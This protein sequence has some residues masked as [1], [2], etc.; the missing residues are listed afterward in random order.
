MQ[1]VSRIALGAALALG[2]AIGAASAQ[3]P[4]PAQA[5]PFAYS[6]EERAALAPVQAAVAAKDYV[7]A[8][9]V[10]AAARTA[11]KSADAQYTFARYQLDIGVATQNNQLQAAGID[12]MI[13]SGRPAAT[14][15]PALYHSQGALAASLGDYKKAETAFARLVEAAPNDAEALV[16]LAEIRNDLGKQAEAVALIDRA[17][18]VRTAA[19]QPVPQN[20]YKRGLNIASASR[21]PAESIKFGRGLAQAYPGPVNWRDA[22]LTYRDF[23]APDPESTLDLLRLM[24]ATGSLAGERD[25]M[26]LARAAMNGEL[27]GEAKAVLDE[28]VAARMIDPAKGEFRDA[29]AAARSKHGSVRAGLAARETRAMAAATGADA[30]KVADAY[31]GYGDHAKAIALYR[32]A[33]QKGSVDADLVNT[34]LGIA[35]AAAGRKAEAE[36]AFRAVTGTRAQLAAY[37]LVW[38][39]QTA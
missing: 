27:A 18:A 12:G 22:L 4:V 23:G 28:G 7:T 39:G 14:E 29:I 15:L 24:R 8:A 33:L 10:A 35:L 1:S 32:A 30:L 25:Y 6:P 19:G 21:M 9:S 2:G 16:K 36:A 37:W 3:A 26:L 20:W 17:I 5:V 11:M 31:A 34:R 13:A 38:L